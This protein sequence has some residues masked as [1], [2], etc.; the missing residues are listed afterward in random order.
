MPFQVPENL[1]LLGRTLGILSGMCTGLDADFNLWQQL[2]PYAKK[3]TEGESGS[4]FDIFLN[5]AGEL[6]KTLIA[7]PGR[8]ERVLAR[9]E[10]GELNVQ[11]PVLTLQ[12]SYLE[13][14]LNRMT[15]GV[16]FLGLVL[17]GALLF[18][19]HA[20]LAQGLFAGAGAALFYTLFLARGKR[21]FR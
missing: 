15:G 16:I 21:P 3:L 4:T 10:R 8:A 11:N 20:L 17:S 19:G 1:L 13:R 18:D 9:M 6:L 5:E 7:I 14:S 2:A 12:V